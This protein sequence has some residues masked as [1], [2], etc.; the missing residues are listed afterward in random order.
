[1]PLLTAEPTGTTSV[2]LFMA[3][4]LRYELHSLGVGVSQL[5]QRLRDRAATS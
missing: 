5:V 2:G 4:L 1:V 3:T